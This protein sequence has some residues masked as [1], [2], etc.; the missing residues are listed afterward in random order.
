[1]RS[2]LN[3]DAILTMILVQPQPQPQY[4]SANPATGNPPSEVSVDAKDQ[5]IADR[6]LDSARKPKEMLVFCGVK[7]KMKIL[8]LFAGGGWY[9]EL[10]ARIAGARRKRPA[11]AFFAPEMTGKYTDK[12]ALLFRKPRT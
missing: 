5:P 6:D 9:C 1:M 12:F 3:Q 2:A 11:P 8:D 4:T 7:P 10:E